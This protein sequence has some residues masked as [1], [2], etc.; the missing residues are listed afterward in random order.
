[1]TA[2]ERLPACLAFPLA[3][4]LAVAALGGILLPGVYAEA[5]PRW[6]AQGVG[7]D[8][9]D[10]VLVAPLLS[11]AAHGV[12]RGSRVAS[13]VLAGMLAYVLYSMVVYA[14]FLHFGPLFLVYTAALGLSFYA[15]VAQVCA[16]NAGDV[17]GWFEA[18]APIRPAGAVS[19]LLGVMFGAL[20]L[21]EIVPALAGAT[22]LRSAREAGLIT[23]PV[24][25]LDLGVVLP[26]FIVGG[27]LLLR[28]RPSG[29]WLV[30]T[31]LAFAVVMDA[32]LVGMTV[33]VRAKIGAEGAP[34]AFLIGS[35]VVTVAVLALLLR[36]VKGSGRF[37]QTTIP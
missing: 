28:R 11:L 4:L 6:A 16:L 13:L 36:S 17:R 2:R 32:A 12:L 23:N 33:S 8:W 10:L 19:V 35:A 21:A 1:V 14:F 30:P 5:H 18:D 37:L 25:V 26:A 20:W 29:Y 31:M 7:Q 27:L 9:V 3:A 34:L 24:E 15:L 22:G